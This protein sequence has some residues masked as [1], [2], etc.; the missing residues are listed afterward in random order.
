MTADPA[1][2]PEVPPG[3]PTR[4]WGR[5]RADLV[6]VLPAWVAARVLVACAWG[7]AVAL[8][9]RD[10]PGG[11][12]VQLDQGLLAWDGAWYEGIASLGYRGLEA[13]VGSAEALRFFPLYPLLGR[14]LGWPLG[15]RD[16]LALVI[17]AN[18][19]ALVVA[20]L[21]RRLVRYETADDALA[22]RA[23]WLLALLPP[24]F[25]LVWAYSEALFLVGA[26]GALLACRRRWWWVAGLLGAVAGA[27][28]PL[29]LLLVL[30]VAVE[31]WEAWR[32]SG[33]VPVGAGA[34][35]PGDPSRRL[36]SVRDRLGALTALAGP[37]VGTGAYLWWVGATTGDALAP[38]TVQQPLRGQA[39]PIS[40]LARGV[41]DLLGPER[42]GDGLH[43]PFAV[44]FVVLAVLTFRWWPRSYGVMAAV[45]LLA[46]LSA[47]NLNSLERYGL[48]AF[49]LVLTL[50]VAVAAQRWERL[51]LAACA[52]GLVS[53]CSLAWLGAYVP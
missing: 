15:G 30:P 4:G 41:G 47:D 18:V 2:T 31:V 48:G 14:V 38:Y 40:R 12:T 29:G 35:G 22:E 37:V 7:L 19:A 27:T 24:A 46:A 50:A 34:V 44:A 52:G 42:W 10:R 39:D 28:R 53:L 33:T 36:A 1:A 23:V 20:V 17:V 11:T 16:A 51:A 9:R 5:W 21:V 26:A 13:A 6:A 3:S 49:P 45:L 8:A 25:V 43:L 32:G